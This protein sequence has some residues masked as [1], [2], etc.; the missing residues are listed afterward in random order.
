MNKTLTHYLIWCIIYNARLCSKQK[1][2]YGTQMLWTC[3]IQRSQHNL[4]AKGHQ[5]LI[6]HSLALKLFVP[7]P[8]TQK[9]WQ[10]SKR[11]CINLCL[12][13]NGLVQSPLW[14]DSK[15][16]AI[17]FVWLSEHC[18]LVYGG[19]TCYSVHW[20]MVPSLELLAYM[21]WQPLSGFLI[22]WLFG[23]VWGSLGVIQQFT[24]WHNSILSVECNNETVRQ[25]KGQKN[26]YYDSYHK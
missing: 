2:L 14:M 1:I 12:Q 18:T 26:N 20:K 9:E 15:V 7:T 10:S 19:I 23:D 8:H 13:D 22:V 4:K 24:T 21:Y 11:H 25:F 6:E 17:G 5:L 16:P 3:G